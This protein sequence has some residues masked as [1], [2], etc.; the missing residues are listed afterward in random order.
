MSDCDNC[1]KCDICEDISEWSDE[2]YEVDNY[3]NELKAAIMH[4]GEEDLQDIEHICKDCYNS[5]LKDSDRF[6][7]NEHD[8]IILK[9]HKLVIS[10]KENRLLYGGYQDE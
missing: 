4:V 9:T 6:E 1:H 10:E 5:Y 3:N 7:I 2:F 8:E